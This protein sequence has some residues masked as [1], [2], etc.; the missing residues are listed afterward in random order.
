MGSLEVLVS[1]DGLG[2]FE[3]ADVAAR[4]R[5]GVQFRAIA[6]EASVK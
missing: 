1:Q 5:E 6:D 3:Q 4:D 2:H